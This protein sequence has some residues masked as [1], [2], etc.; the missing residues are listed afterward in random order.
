MFGKDNNHCAVVCGGG[1][2]NQLFQYVFARYLESKYNVDVRLIK[3][4]ES[5]YTKTSKYF[6]GRSSIY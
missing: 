2:G 6:F 1:L 3:N 4:I 5:G